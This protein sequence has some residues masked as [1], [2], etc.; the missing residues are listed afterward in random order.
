MWKTRGNM[1]HPIF[2]NRLS[3]RSYTFNWPP[4]LR[5]NGQ[6]QVATKDPA[7]TGEGVH[8]CVMLGYLRRLPCLQLWLPE[9]QPGLPAGWGWSP[10][11]GR[12]P[13][14]QGVWKGEGRGEP[15]PGY[16]AFLLPHTWSNRIGPLRVWT[17]SWILNGKVRGLIYLF[18]TSLYYNYRTDGLLFLV[19]LL[20]ACMARVAQLHDVSL[21]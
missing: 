9:L 10:C 1:G 15:C 17:R 20:W 12:P 3:G 14:T 4:V 5:S 21:I 8:A 19:Q 6:G 11:L 18:L 7:A 2:L 16:S 13:G